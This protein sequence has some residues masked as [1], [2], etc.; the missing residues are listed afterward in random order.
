VPAG[1]YY[2]FVVV[3]DPAYGNVVYEVTKTNNTSGALALA[4]VT[5]DLA[6]VTVG[7]PVS[8][9]SGTSIQVSCL[10][11]NRGS[12]RAAGYW[13]DGIYF[14]TNAVPNPTNTTLLAAVFLNHNL[15]AGS[16]Y[17]WTN[18]VSLPQVPAGTY[19]LFVVVDDPAYG[20]VVYEVTKTNNTSGGKVL[21]IGAPDLAVNGITT[22]ASAVV[23]QPVQ[24]VLAIT[25]QG[26]AM[27]AGP[28]FNQILLANNTNGIGAHSLGMFTFTSA[29]LAGG[30]TTI[31]QTAILP[32][33]I[34]GTQY[35]G[36]I[37][38]SA[39]SVPEIN[40]SN[41]TKFATNPIVIGAP[42]LVLARLS[43]P[44]TSQ[45]GQ[46]FNVQFAV[47]NNGGVQAAGAWN[48]QV[49]LASDTNSLAG[50]TV[51]ATAAGYSPLAPGNG[52]SRTQAVTLPLTAGVAPG[53]YYIAAVADSGNALSESTKT[54]NIA[55]TPIT[56]S[57]PPLADLT[58]GQASSSPSALAGQAVAVSWG[59]TNVGSGVANGPWREA[60]YLVSA[61]LSLAQF[62][63]NQAAYPLIGAFTY[64]NN[65]APLGSVMRT[66][67]VTVPWNGLAGDLRVAVVVN[68][69]SSLVEQTATNNSA[70]GLNDLQVPTALSITVPVA[71]V[72]KNSPT[73]NLTCLISRNGD[74]TTPASVSL[75]STATNA[76][77]VP[78]TV[79]IPAG[80][81]SA[82]FTVTVLDDGVPGP[83]F[84]VTLAAS[85]AGYVGATSQVTVVNTDLPKLG[86]SLA[87][88]PIMEGQTVTAIVTVVPASNKPLTVTLANPSPSSLA[89]P[90]AIVIPANSNSASFTVL[91][92]Q[93]TIIA[94]DR[95]YTIS[96]SVNG[97]TSSSASLTVLN[98]N[99]P[100]LALSLD[101]TNINEADGP[102]AAVATISRYPITDQPVTMALASTNTGA[103]L[104]PG[105]ATIPALQGSAAVYVAAVNDTNV[106]GPKVTLISAQALDILGNP[107]GTPVSQAL[108]VQDNNGPVLRLSLASKVVPKGTN[109]TGL[110]RIATANTNDL[111]VTLTSGATNEATVPATITIPAGQTSVTFPVATLE[112]GVPFTR[113]EV[114]ITA[115]AKNYA[116]GSDVLTVTD[117]GGP[118]LVIASI[119]APGAAFTAEPLTIGFRLIN[120]GLGAL[121]NSVTQNVYFTT[122]PVAGNYILVGSAYSLGSLAPGQYA[123]Q[124]SLV[125][126]SALPPPGNYWVVVVAD[127]NNNAL[128]LNEANNYSVSSAPIVVS[129]EYTATVKAGVTNALLGATVPLY[130]SATMAVGGPATN[131][132]VNLLVTLRGLQRTIGVFTDGN[133]NFSTGF[134]PLPNEAG[135]YTVSAVSPGV[136][137]APPQD[138][139]NILGASFTPGSLALSLTE[140]DHLAAAASLQNLCEVPLSG[141]AVTVNGLAAN[142]TASPTLNT[143]Y[144]GGEGSVAMSLDVTASDAS[145]L[146]SSFTIHLT[147]AEGVILDFPVSVTVNPLMPRLVTAPAQL[148]GSMLRGAQ[149]IV[150]FQV[151]NAGGAASGPLAV[152]LPAVPWMSV[153]S[154]NPLPS[155][156]PGQSN[157]VTLVLSPAVDLPLGPYT[158]NLGVNGTGTGL[159]IPFTFNAVSDARGSLLVQSVDEYTFFAAGAPPLTNASVTLIDPYSQ[160][161]VAKGVTD[162]NGIF[163]IPSVIEGV[164]ELDVAAD[165]HA[166]FKGSGLVTSGQ[167]NTIQAFLSRQT[168]TYTWTVVP[169]QIQDQTLLTV[170]TTFETDVPA[171][172]IVPTPASLDLSALSQ[173]G[174]FMDVPLTLANHGLIAV[175]NVALSVNSSALYRFDLVTTNI[176][177]LPAHGTVTVPMRITMLATGVA[178]SSITV[179]AKQSGATRGVATPRDASYGPCVPSLGWV[180]S[181]LCGPYGVNSGAQLPINN[182][183]TDCGGISFPS[184]PNPI[185]VSCPFCGGGWWGGTWNAPPSITM[186]SVCDPCLQKRLEAMGLC[187]IELVPLNHFPDCL[188]GIALCLA[189]LGDCAKHP[190]VLDC[191]NA[192]VGCLKTGAE[193]LGK[194]FGLLGK[195]Y[196][197]LDC[198]HSVCTACDGMPGHSG[199]C[200]LSPSSNSS[201]LSRQKDLAQSQAGS[202]TDTLVSTLLS[203]GDDVRTLLAPYVYFYG[204]SVWFR[205]TDTNAL[206]GVLDQFNASI[207]T[208]SDGAQ[209]ITPAEQV[210]LLSLPLP[211]PL[212]SSDLN[213]LIGRWNNTM[214]NYSVGIF[215][216]NQVPL[217]G[218]TNFIA[219]DQWSS[220]NQGAAQV[221]QTYENEGYT[222]PAS[223]WLVT[224][225]A[226]LADVQGGSSGTCAQ[227]KLQIDQTAT[228]T[229]DAFHATLEL[230]NNGT[231]L[232]TNVTVTLR[233]ENQA[234]QDATSLFGVQPP[235]LTGS[236]TAVDGTGVLAPNAA[237]AAQWTLVP[238]LDAAPQAPT[239][240]LVSG[241]FSYTQNGLAVTIPLSPQVITVQ[242]SPELYVKYF[243]QRDVFADDPFTPQIE[244]SIPF[245]LAMMVQNRGYGTA[246]NFQITSAQPRIVDNVKGLLINFTIIGTDLAGLPI[247]PSLTVN[248]GDIGPGGIKIG[249]WLL[250]SSL[251]GLFI[252]YAATFQHV[253]P[254][255]NPR[256]SL[257][258]G[259]EIH[260]MTHSVRA[261]G[262]WDD[263]QPDFLVNDV[264]D[265]GSLPDTLYLSD[266][267]VQPVS[268]VQAG[269]ADA[270]ASAGHLHVQLTASFPAGFSYVLVPDPANGRFPLLAVQRSNGTGLL[271]E[272][273]YTTDRTFIGLGQRP[274]Y[275]NKLH[276]F[277]YHTNAG[278]DTYTLVYGMPTNSINTNPPVSAVFSLPTQSPPTFGVAWSGAPYVGGASIA[279]FDIYVSDNGGP[280]TIWQSQTTGTGALFKG[281]NGHV[282]AFYSVAT[283]TA[284]HREATPLA[285]QAQTTV[286]PN[287]IPPTINAIPGVTLNAGETLSLSVTASTPNPLN[288]LT[289]SIGSG[290][291]A[292]VSID[293]VSGHLTWPTSPALG[294]TTNS[295]SI[296][297]TDNGQPPLS[298]TSAVTVVLLRVVNP[299]VL[300]PIANYRI[301]E[302]T[303]LVI[304]NSATDNNLPPRPI[305]FS[306]GAGAPA[307]ATI[308]PVAGVFQW[309]PTAAQAP[310]TN[311]IAVMVTDDGIPP[312]SATQQFTV[313]VRP[314]A[315]EFVLVFGSTNLLAGQSSSV[316]IIVASS[317]NLTS[318]TATL[319]TP[320]VFLT[321]LTLASTSGETTG[322]LLES[323]GQ[324][325]YAIGLTLD[326]A[327][328]PGGSRAVAKLNFLA[329]P[330]SHSATVP[331][332]ALTASALQASGLAA[333]KPGKVSG[334]VIIVG[335]EPIL[336][337]SLTTNFT[338]LL[339]LYGNPGST[340][341]L[342]YT[343]NLLSPNW[344]PGAIVALT[345]LSQYLVPDQAAPQIYYRAVAPAP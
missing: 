234:G 79:T 294:G 284:G 12:G 342:N 64:T 197:I 210:A 299:P 322:T 307:N 192:I 221:L 154:V 313:I 215:T 252:D 220:L 285:P 188:R 273:F 174:Q 316:P 283:D 213:A 272:N 15:S 27:A 117:M 331:L 176:G 25:N 298:S 180:Y 150:Q 73:P 274:I 204:S 135:H 257:I 66:Q 336:E 84:Q 325:Q 327:A 69:D 17:G 126:G 237:G 107:I 343:T 141:L 29:L 122:D 114:T 32:Q 241:T 278:P 301:N 187:V 19:Y 30:S 6:P 52:Y 186:P 269:T 256:L 129:P 280:F 71:S 53:K 165:Q 57:L 98:N 49:Y 77:W 177:L 168:V 5:P 103:A 167:T 193:C 115:S 158:G 48:D 9:V 132:P 194:N 270:P 329:R 217:G 292:G 116:S 108:V 335:T 279:Y 248:F 144:L 152:A 105:E 265:V 182:A 258:Q 76:L 157:Q 4:A 235:T 239:N 259:V 137:S 140:G 200:G 233:V 145:I 3:D 181:Y 304:T 70:L 54:N 236:L 268:V 22:P 201:S 291:P 94:P 13:Y 228:L 223:A 324:D 271:A 24:L 104:V 218:D 337:A 91:A 35:F 183:Q 261:D 143:N 296:I 142:L 203:Q 46:A 41:N 320:A 31:T 36:V 300:A 110:L 86:L 128:E 81:G 82:P 227:V 51:L 74:L 97:Y 224:R 99:A 100:T 169:T 87:T 7:A 209:F 136:A 95:T 328:S 47:T 89:V 139:F 255:G 1:T 195:I 196:D 40:R 315:N 310:S 309:R 93:N 28:W 222:D 253:D 250:T 147:S 317:L 205:V 216:T 88:S 43:A 78:A 18:P 151:V 198:V 333:D 133:G 286:A 75:F 344:K 120:Q 10:V 130:G 242:P 68:S 92:V 230:N 179:N 170:Q 275:E 208:N 26:N 339:T 254:L 293:P 219:F 172:V 247:S 249:E 282:Y 305:T 318:V 290:A 146:Q 109:T 334:H 127:A 153:A 232:L 231:D 173:P 202:Q 311:L 156:A 67:Q 163:L 113:Q 287:T 80:A 303:L 184:A 295:I 131:K 138:Q 267:T 226:L 11:T 119:T 190:E 159:Q 245:P 308:N 238:S 55:T 281:T 124:T 85:A 306:L 243:L 330:Q 246:H 60:V 166:P 39:S 149:T 262:A 240:Y 63:T 162:A 90:N 2:L 161:A 345:N 101:R 123:D 155:L 263:G 332:L 42:D 171:P 58:V 16:S 214:S 56:L 21:Q 185:A 212:S 244:P 96:A 207:Q 297:V 189:G 319:Q 323:L 340:Y 148:R 23:A 191:Y 34:T 289:F 8:G 111:L 251:Q 175:E 211:S 44:A 206:G 229:R 37:L 266:G 125:P 341:Q 112:D 160:A 260:E 118:D 164:Y 102:F 134:K 83:N 277:D 314:V 45:F 326:P 20:N 61:A 50:A 312:L 178:K 288:I 264:P 199:V 62:G 72:L 33:S 338:P 65:L 14:S 302:A 106:T 321:N 225:N 59:V 38:D 121:T 276:V